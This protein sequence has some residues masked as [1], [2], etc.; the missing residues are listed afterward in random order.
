M[1]GL[2]SWAAEELG[3][4]TSPYR[5]EDTEHEYREAIRT[6]GL[7]CVIKPVMSSSGKGQST[8]VLLRR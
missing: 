5:F 3:L 2:P 6:L 4:P 1:P 8:A 7:P